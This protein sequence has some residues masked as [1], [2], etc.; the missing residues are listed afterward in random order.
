MAITSRISG[1]SASDRDKRD[2]NVELARFTDT[3]AYSGAVVLTHPLETSVAD[4]R[5]VESAEYGRNLN[6]NV[7][8]SGT[9]DQIHDGT[10]EVLWTGSQIVGTSITFNSETHA[11]AAKAAVLD[12]TG[13][14]GATVTID[15]S[16]VTEGVDWTAAT[17]NNATATSLASAISGISGVSATAT[18]AIVEVLADPGGDI[19]VVSTSDGGTNL[20]ITARSVLADNPD[21]GDVWQ[22]DKGSDVTMSS[23]TALTFAIYVDKDWVVGDE[24]E[25]FAW[26]TSAGTAIGDTVSLSPLFTF[27]DFDE[28]HNVTIP[29]TDFGAAATS[30]LVD[31]FRIRVSARSGPKSPVFYMD[32]IQLEQSG[33]ETF[34]VS[35]LGEERLFVEEL[36]FTMV[37]AVDSTL[38]NAS[39]PNLAY[40]QFLGVTKL[41]NGMQLRWTDDNLVRITETYQQLFDL[42]AFGGEVCCWFHDG[43]NT[44]IQVRRR[45]EAPIILTGAAGDSLSLIVSD[46]LSGLVEFTVAAVGRLQTF[47]KI[48]G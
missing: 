18:A 23:Y 48:G 10:D 31:S 1:A 30:S 5:F 46:D 12:Y 42:V 2:V 28:W 19:L 14:S 11:Y 45:F 26:D 33:S 17:S 20:T 29:L 36:V 4:V 41:V 27:S 6:Q 9:P 34:E 15:G 7:G 43:T 39:M 37:D 32:H 44:M 40:N 22:F 47:D 8:F 21:V 24:V 35:V 13:L 25:V 16:T 3:V 38:S